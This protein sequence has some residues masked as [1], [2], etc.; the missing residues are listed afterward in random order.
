MKKL[1]LFTILFFT[2]CFYG[3]QTYSF[4]YFIE[5]EYI[6]PKENKVGTFYLLTNSKDNSYHVHLSAEDSTTFNLNFRTE[7]FRS[8]SIVDRESFINAKTIKLSCESVALQKDKTNLKRYDFTNDS[9][10]LI[11]NKKYKRYSMQ[12]RKARDSKKYKTAKSFYVVENATEFHTPL[13]LLSSEFDGYFTSELFPNGIAK[14]VYST[15][16]F[17]PKS[18]YKLVSY[19]KVNKTIIIPDCPKLKL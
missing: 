2:T 12:Y 3:Q 18:H 17:G 6:R 5:Y 8:Y 13:L 19:T 4:D 7:N 9:D 1:F 10:T 15:S 16:E 11:E 14:E